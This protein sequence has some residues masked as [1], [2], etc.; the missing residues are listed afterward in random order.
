MRNRIRSGLGWPYGIAD[1]ARVAQFP[2]DLAKHAQPN[3]GV[4]G[5]KIQPA[6]EPAYALVRIRDAAKVSETAQF[7]RFEQQRG[8][9]FDL[10]R[11]GAGKLAGNA[12]QFRVA[13]QLI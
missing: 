12:R 9:A 8:D 4:A 7:E 3:Y 6:H 11:G 2:G 5:R 1:G 10:C 13:N